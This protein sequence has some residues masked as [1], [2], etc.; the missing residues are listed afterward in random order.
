MTRLNKKIF[1]SPRSVESLLIL[2]FTTCFSLFIL[3]ILFSF[4]SFLSLLVPACPS[5]SQLVPAWPSQAQLGPAWPNLAQLALEPIKL[6]FI[7]SGIF[8]PREANYCS[9]PFE[10]LSLLAKNLKKSMP[11]KIREI[12]KKFFFR[13]TAVLH[14]T[15]YFQYLHLR[16]QLVISFLEERPTQTADCLAAM[17]LLQSILSPSSTRLTIK[18]WDL[19]V[20]QL[21]MEE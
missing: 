10:V 8:S 3:F 2:T 20:R 15:N 4:L 18:Q 1:K 11:K 16:F 9:N 5:L 19:W 6:H 21:K 12:I 7:L 17:K 13:E 14:F